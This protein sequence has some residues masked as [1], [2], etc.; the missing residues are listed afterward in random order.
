MYGRRSSRP[1]GT[2]RRR[3]P[4]GGSPT[5]PSRESRG[6]PRAS[7]SA[8]RPA[9]PSGRCPS[10]VGRPRGGRGRLPGSGR[11]TPGPRTS[12]GS[13]APAGGSS[14]SPRSREGRA[15]GGDRPR[16]VVVGRGL[17]RRSRRAHRGLLA[18]AGTH[19]G[20][21]RRRGVRRRRVRPGAARRNHGVL[22]RGS[23]GRGGASWTAAGHRPSPGLGAYPL[24]FL[25]GTGTRASGRMTLYLVASVR[26]VTT[27]AD[28]E[29]RPTALG[30]A[31]PPAHAP[32]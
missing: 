28:L 5:R 32:S 25:L 14:P 11:A 27:A 3:A 19:P 7:S 12:G 30:G 4:D 17:G 21:T 31:C 10:R 15:A 6:R 26:F 9:T 1:C 8:W 16:D 18:R 29:L 23:A 24:L 2:S 13:P 20:R 22:L